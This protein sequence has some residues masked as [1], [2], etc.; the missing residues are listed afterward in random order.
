MKKLFSLVLVLINIT[1]SQLVLAEDG[2][3]LHQE[4]CI[5]CHVA[6]TGGDGSLLYTRKDHKVSSIE[7]LTKQ[8]N[9]C[10]SSLGLNWSES[11]ISAV[12]KYLNSTYYNF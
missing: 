11:Q 9:R 5:A 2:G 12:Q 4:N 6:M 1:V 7:T 3:I 8:V 10:Q